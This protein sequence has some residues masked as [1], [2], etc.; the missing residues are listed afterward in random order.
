M[1]NSHLHQLI[2]CVHRTSS[3]YS[4]KDSIFKKKQNKVVLSLDDMVYKR[5]NHLSLDQRCIVD[6][7]STD[8]MSLDQRCIFAYKRTNHMSLDQRQV[9]K[10]CNKRLN[11]RKCM[12]MLNIWLAVVLV[13]GDHIYNISPQVDSSLKALAPS[14]TKII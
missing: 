7:K 8:H 4:D 9:F 13:F 2:K 3:F 11:I 12:C 1:L 5:T 6:Y 10:I 14:V